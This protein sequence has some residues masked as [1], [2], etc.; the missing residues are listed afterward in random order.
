[1]AKD[2]VV[3]GD[4]EVP[5]MDTQEEVVLVEIMEIIEAVEPMLVVAD[6]MVVVAV[7]QI[8]LT[9]KLEMVEVAL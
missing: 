1:M 4:W 6:Y 5:Q 9:M 3:L 7:V 2:P 8:I